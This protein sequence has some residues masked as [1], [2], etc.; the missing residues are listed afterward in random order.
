MEGSYRPW[1]LTDRL[2]HHAPSVVG[3]DD[4]GKVQSSEETLAISLP[5]E[6]TWNL[7]HIF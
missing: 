4:A 3:A 5:Q 2:R 7:R 6:L 1:L